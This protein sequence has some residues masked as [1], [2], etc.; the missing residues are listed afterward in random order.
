MLAR[1]SGRHDG[2]RQLQGGGLELG[3]LFS[4]RGCFKPVFPSGRRHLDQCRNLPFP[5]A[6]RRF[7][8]FPCS[9]RAALAKEQISMIAHL[10]VFLASAPF[11]VA[12]GVV[13]SK[14]HWFTA[15]EI[16]FWCVAIFVLSELVYLG[17]S[18]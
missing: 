12:L 1:L 3:V 5:I 13:N 15:G 10:L 4:H 6:D 16:R 9:R 17:L 7:A 18:A 2:S 8:G 11:Q 14:R